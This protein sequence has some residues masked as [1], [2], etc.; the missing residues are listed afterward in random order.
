MTL[1]LAAALATDQ[2]ASAACALAGG[3]VQG[4]YGVSLTDFGSFQQSMQS[5]G[6]RLEARPWRAATEAAKAA[7]EAVRAHQRRGPAPADDAKARR[8]SRP[9]R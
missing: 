6:M 4:G 5:A 9:A 8:P 7:D 1:E 2:A 3:P